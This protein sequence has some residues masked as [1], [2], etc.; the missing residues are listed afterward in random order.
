MGGIEI[1]YI[2]FISVFTAFP[3]LARLIFC[4]RLLLCYSSLSIVP[5][6]PDGRSYFHENT[7]IFILA[8]PEQMREGHNCQKFGH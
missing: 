1:P 2:L 6:R 8:S 4:H 5:S 7:A 3:F